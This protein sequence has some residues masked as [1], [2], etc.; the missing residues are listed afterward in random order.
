M[1]HAHERTTHAVTGAFGYSGS[2]IA[3]RLLAAGHEVRTLTGR[4]PRAHPLGPLVERTP[5]DLDDPA[6]LE[7]DLAGVRT[8]TN[9]YWVRFSEAGFSMQRAVERSARLFEAA[10]RA[11]VERIVHVS[12]TNPSADS[13]YAYFRGKAAVEEAL[14][15]T[16]VPH[17]ILR[18]AVFFGGGD[19]LV[20]NI[21][22]ALRHL[23]VF[24]MFGDGGYRLQPIHVDDFADLAAAAAL[25][26][27]DRPSE[28]LDAVGPEAF[29]YRE[30]A[31]LL[32][33]I[34]GARCAIA[35]M[36]TGLALGSVRLLGRVLGDVTLTREEVGALMDDLLV[37]DRRPTGT[38]LLSE[39]AAAHAPELG[40]CYHC[41]LDR[42]SHSPRRAG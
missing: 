15:A 5:L 26:Q 4:G 12:I 41:E 17:T 36:P 8:L 1:E 20:N 6:A 19:I 22:W 31:E 3:A 27:T 30:L 14:A 34:L 13:P 38:T 40:R 33:G 28:V 32:R 39:W 35:G 16:G 37:S 9:T 11:G 29:T 2:R 24:G 21:A 25:G 7:R 42:R 10:R 18:P 23:P